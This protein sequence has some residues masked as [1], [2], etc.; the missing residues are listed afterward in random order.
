[1]KQFNFLFILIAFL[2]FTTGVVQGIGEDFVDSQDHPLISRYSD[3]IIFAYEDVAFDEYNLVLGSVTR[4]VV[5]LETIPFPGFY[6]GRTL[7]LPSEFK[8]LEGRVNK[9]T[10]LVPEGRSTLEIFRNYENELINGGFEILYSAAGGEVAYFGDWHGGYYYLEIPLEGVRTAE[11]GNYLRS[12]N[13]SRFLTGVLHREEGDIYVSLYVHNGG[14]TSPAHRD[15]GKVQ[16][17][18]IEVAPMEEGLVTVDNLYEGITRTGS[19]SIYGIEFGF[20]S[21]DINPES[22]PVLREI[23]NL[24]NEFPGLEL[25][26]VGHTDDTGSLDYNIG[27]SERRAQAVVE[28]LVNSLGIDPN[29]LTARGVGPLA[30]V[31]SNETESGRA[32]NRRVELVKKLGN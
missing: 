14:I 7:Y 21:A 22:E 10:Y 5:D 23:A 8:T 13:D 9:I 27:L 12:S 15:L 16:L 29:R 20:D 25:Y 3:S 26:V 31:A 32:K 2:F 24:L 6:Q 1:M 17:D 18:I 28:Y 4:E 19:I 30:P 11:R